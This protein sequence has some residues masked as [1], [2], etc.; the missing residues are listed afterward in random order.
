MKQ[1]V[2]QHVFSKLLQKRRWEQIRKLMHEALSDENLYKFLQWLYPSEN[3]PVINGH[4]YPVAL[5]PA[6]RKQWDDPDSV[7]VKAGWN[8]PETVHPAL[9]KAGESYRK[10]RI[11][12]GAKMWNGDIYRMV[13][14]ENKDSLK[15]YCS[16]GKYFTAFETCHMLELE[17]LTKFAEKHPQNKDEFERFFQNELKLR[18]LVHNSIKEPTGIS[19]IIGVSTLILFQHKDHWKT[20]LIKRSENVAT[21]S[22]FIHVTPSFI[23]QPIIGDYDEEFSIKHNIYREYLEELFNALEPP[24]K[25]V[26][27]HY[28]YGHPNLKYLM[29]LEKEQKARLLFTGVA[30]NLITLTPEICT[31]LQINTNEWYEKHNNPSTGLTPLTTN[32]ESEKHIILEIDNNL[33]FPNQL[34]PTKIT[35]PG[36]AT[37]ILGLNTAK[38]T[39]QEITH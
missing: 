13:K 5:Y 7:L 10:L 9:K 37:L 35:P 23:F 26:S 34:T 32:E 15:I 22:G 8:I 33:S 28:F 36:A 31:L 24:K 18:R 3:I 30:I 16:I 38:Q 11:A 4:Y 1:R 27:P 17:L 29:K 19:A 25:Q 12:A 2:E 6:P 20:I 21:F 39:I 14:F